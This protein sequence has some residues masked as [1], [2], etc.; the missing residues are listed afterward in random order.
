MQHVIWRYL[1]AERERIASNLQWLELETEGWDFDEDAQRF[2]V[3]LCHRD[4]I[5]M[6]LLDANEN[7]DVFAAIDAMA[8]DLDAMLAQMADGGAPE[9][10]MV[11]ASVNQD[12]LLGLRVRLQ[13]AIA[14]LTVPYALAG[15]ERL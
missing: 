13:A 15:V 14:E 9:A 4:E 11:Q 1:Q 2:Y 3:E 12:Y 10:D 6:A 5:V 8:D 7:A